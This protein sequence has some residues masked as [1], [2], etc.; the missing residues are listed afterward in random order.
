M[1]NI[2][3]K[4]YIKNLNAIYD[5]WT[6][7]FLEEWIRVFVKWLWQDIDKTNFLIDWVD[8]VLMQFTWLYDKNRKEIFDWD[9][10]EI[11]YKEWDINWF[12][13]WYRQK[14]EI[15]LNTLW[16]CFWNYTFNFIKYD[17]IFKVI[18]NIYLN[19]ELLWNH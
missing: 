19:P 6:M 7:V 8:N 2:K 3:F 18:W 17:Y 15:K 12:E 14:Q 9:I 4:A 11:G 5:V 13:K 10:V 16:H 1:N